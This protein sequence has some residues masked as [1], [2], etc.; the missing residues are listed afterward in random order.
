MD[1]AKWNG[2]AFICP[3]RVEDNDTWRV[4]ERWDDDS[5]GYEEFEEEDEEGDH[6]Y[7][8]EVCLMDIARPARPRGTCSVKVAYYEK[9]ELINFFWLGVKKEFEVVDKLPGVIVLE[10]EEEE[11]WR[12]Y[13]D[14]EQPEEDWEEILVEGTGAAR[15]SFAEVLK[16]AGG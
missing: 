9:I 14:W 11:V 7:R 10:D 5:D 3:G 15:S 16:A 6:Y 13:G 12:F 1:G 4:P 8:M 2:S